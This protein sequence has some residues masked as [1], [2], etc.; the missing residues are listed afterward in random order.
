MSAKQPNVETNQDKVEQAI[1]D[2]GASTG[3]ELQLHTGLEA[4]QVY[5]AVK[6]LKC[7]GV[8]EENGDR[9][10]VASNDMSSML[11]RNVWNGNVFSG[12]FGQ[13]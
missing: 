4:K 8:I 6:D 2:H 12:V 1:R 11:N 7:A 13:A 10:Q 3:Y 5:V 9:Y